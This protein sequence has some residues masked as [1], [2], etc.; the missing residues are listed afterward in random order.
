[1]IAGP[2]HAVA[3][4]TTAFRWRSTRARHSPPRSTRTPTRLFDVTRACFDRYH[5]LFGVRYPFGHYHQAFVPEFNDGRDGEPGLRHVPRRL[6][7]PSAVTDAEREER[8]LVIAH[9]MA[10]MWFGDLV[11]MC[12][13]DDLWL[14]ESFAE[15]LGHRV[16]AEVTR[17]TNAGR[18]SRSGRKAWG[19]AADQR[20]STHPVSADVVDTDEALLNFDGISYAKGAAV[21]KQL[22]AL[23][24]DD[25][26]FAGLR[27]HFDAHAY[28]NAV[29]GRPPR[30][31]RR[32]GWT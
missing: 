19:Y 32:R 4:N 3:T 14:N 16:T 15:Y 7:F 10:H 26:F 1:M 5:E 13:W 20:P 28:G 6:R 18:R 23:L 21:L 9:E 22:V 30:R 25:A 27:A 2:Y 8:A 31:A 24:G 29:P 17:F 11:T 12:W